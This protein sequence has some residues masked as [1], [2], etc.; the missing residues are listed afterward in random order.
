MSS[1][2][3]FLDKLVDNSS[4][5]SDFSEIL[6]DNLAE[7]TLPIPPQCRLVDFYLK[8]VD[9]WSSLVDFLDKLVDNSS[10]MSDF[11]ENLVDNLV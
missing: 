2:V 6:V 7:G 9:F 3:D 8:L 10:G 4:G 1:L 5:V 11:S